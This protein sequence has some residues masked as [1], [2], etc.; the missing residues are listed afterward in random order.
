MLGAIA[1]D[2]IGSVHEFLGTKT[3]DFPLF[4][5]GS[6]FTDD[7]VLTVAVADCLLTGAGHG[8]TGTC[9]VDKFHEYA[10]R[11]PNRCYGGRFWDWVN[12]GSREPYNSWGN[13]SAMRV[14]PVGWAFDDLDAVLL[15]AKRSAEVTHDHPE[16]I[17]GAQATAAA[18]LLARHGE[19]RE[20]I[21]TAIQERFGYDLSGTVNSIRPHYSFNE[22]CQGTVPQ[23]II[24]FLDSTDYED[25]VRLAISLGGDA[26]TLACITGGIAEAFYGG[27]PTEIGEQALA[28]LDPHLRATVSGFYEKFIPAGAESSPSARF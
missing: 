18:I 1:G 16:G 2:I 25:A 22:T 14:S 23:A 19:P 3:K 4:V 17:R 28:I 8:G 27:V 7:S 9:Y 6:R 12:S 26:D 20:R 11:Y 13:G 21:R 24:A 5:E 10:N 15:E